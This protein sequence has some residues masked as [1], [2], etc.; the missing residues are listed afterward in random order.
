MAGEYCS[1]GFIYGGW[2]GS[3]LGFSTDFGLGK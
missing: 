3:F 1:F 2:G